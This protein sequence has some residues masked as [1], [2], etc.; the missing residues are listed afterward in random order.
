MPWNVDESLQVHYGKKNF[1]SREKRRKSSK[2]RRK[3]RMH[4][5]GN[6]PLVRRNCVRHAHITTKTQFTRARGLLQP[7]REKCAGGKCKCWSFWSFP[8]NLISTNVGTSAG[9]S[10]SAWAHAYVERL[11]MMRASAT[12]KQKLFG[13]RAESWMH[14][15]SFVRRRIYV[16]RSVRMSLYRT[17][18]KISTSFAPL[19]GHQWARNTSKM[20]S[21]R[22]SDRN[23]RQTTTEVEWKLFNQKR[24][25]TPAH[26]SRAFS[27]ER[28]TFYN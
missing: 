15:E 20:S 3:R 22:R 2:S 9:N 26:L 5:P 11:W 8:P 21:A 25:R 13:L 24:M 12:E 6:W 17:P 18:S 14:Q 23:G 16:V 19:M 1:S 4:I 10:L 28:C 27:N 7:Q